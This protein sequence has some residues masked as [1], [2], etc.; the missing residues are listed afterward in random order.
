M[1]ETLFDKLYSAGKQVFDELKKPVVKNK[2]KRKLQAA[3]DDAS[4][5]IGE[6]ELKIQKTREN[7]D[8]YDVNTILEQ[9]AIIT[10]AKGLQDQIKAEY[11]ELFGK[12]MTIEVD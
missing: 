6:S 10:Q 12:D 3:F 2:I 11:K 5:K 7:F 1:S 9:K 4:L 8:G